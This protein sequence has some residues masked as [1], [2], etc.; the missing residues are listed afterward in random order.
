MTYMVQVCGNFRLARVFIIHT[1][2]DEIGCKTLFPPKTVGHT[3]DYAGF[4]G[5][6]F[7]GVTRPDLIT[8]GPNV[9]SVEAC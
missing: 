8:Q 7:W 1:R 5:A 6:G 2:P 3:V 4:V 9:D